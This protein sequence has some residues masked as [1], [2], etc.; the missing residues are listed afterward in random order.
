MKKYNFKFTGRQTGAIGIFYPI[1]D[2]YQAKDINEAMSLLYEDYEHLSNL[3]IK[4]NGKEIDQPDKIKWVEV[5]KYS[6]RE[7]NPKTGI[8]LY[9]RSDTPIT[10]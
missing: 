4:E 6:E 5:R 1:A 7:R 8:Y 10:K 2:T 9:T 3:S